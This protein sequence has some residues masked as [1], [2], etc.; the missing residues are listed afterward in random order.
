ML[1]SLTLAVFFLAGR[2]RNLEAMVQ[3]MVDDI[4]KIVT[5]KT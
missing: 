1:S 3:M 2:V 4:L 5:I